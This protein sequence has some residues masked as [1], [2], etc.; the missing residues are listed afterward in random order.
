MTNQE[1]IDRLHKDKAFKDLVDYI[2][3]Q[4]GGIE[5]EQIK[6]VIESAYKLGHLHGHI[7]AL[8]D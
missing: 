7:E 1:K 3:N 5:L 8:T 6:Y 2:W 4:K